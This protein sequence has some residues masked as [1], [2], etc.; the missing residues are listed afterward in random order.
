MH[1]RSVY[2]ETRR[3]RYDWP[4]VLVLIAP[5][6]LR[7]S[8]SRLLLQ[9]RVRLNAAN[10]VN[11]LSEDRQV[12]FSPVHVPFTPPRA[13]HGVYFDTVHSAEC[14][15]TYNTLKATV[16]AETRQALLQAMAMSLSNLWKFLTFSDPKCPCFLTLKFGSTLFHP[17]TVYGSFMV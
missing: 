11:H 10:M 4:V 13:V 16:H 5:R 15:G 12:P 7:I 17:I 1:S 8:I 9:F 2:E 14:T 6:E 3:N